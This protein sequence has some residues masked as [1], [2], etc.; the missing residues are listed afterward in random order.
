MRI[1]NLINIIL[2]LGF[3]L[4]NGFLAS[5]FFLGPKSKHEELL[6]DFWPHLISRFG[7]MMLPAVIFVLILYLLNLL[8][9]SVSREKMENRQAYCLKVALLAL[10]VLAVFDFAGCLIFFQAFA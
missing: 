7:F 2:V 9:T 1:M 3:G 10:L 5:Y 6:A 8:M 4:V